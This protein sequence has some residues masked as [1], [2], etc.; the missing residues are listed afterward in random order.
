MN[1]GYTRPVS[2]LE[3][4]HRGLRDA[5]KRS[6]HGL[7]ARTLTREG[8]CPFQHAVQVASTST[9]LWRATSAKGS[10]EIGGLGLSAMDLDSCYDWPLK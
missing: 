10:S 5:A 6:I 4:I 7:A 2:F 8:S 1:L 9:H 3:R